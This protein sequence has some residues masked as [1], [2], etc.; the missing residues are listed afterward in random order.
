MKKFLIIAALFIFS[1]P[2]FSAVRYVTT[3]APMHNSYRTMPRYNTINRPY[4]HYHGNRY[5]PPPK[6][7]KYNKYKNYNRNYNR[8]RSYYPGTST[9]YTTGNST[10]G[11]GGFFQNLKT[12][13]FG[14]PTGLT[15]PINPYYSYGP[16][17]Y[18][19]NY[20]DYQDYYSNR[21]W[22]MRNKEIGTGTGVQILD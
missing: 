1:V 3:S 9:Y 19:S 15:P 21:G 18:G 5:N 8:L 11:L 2:A 6:I 12:S 22:A 10:G 20:G 17:S 7:R 16:N 14:T 13:F 4:T